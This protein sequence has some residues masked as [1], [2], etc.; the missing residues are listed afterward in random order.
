MQ[1]LV[2][3]LIYKCASQCLN[4]CFAITYNSFATLTARYVLFETSP[5]KEKAFPLRALKFAFDNEINHSTREK[6]RVA[7]GRSR[8]EVLLKLP[9]V[10]VSKFHSKLF[11]WH[12]KRSSIVGIG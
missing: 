3:P 1:S 12:G 2:T 8:S 4:T 9:S 7:S 11:N 6:W 5:A 10:L